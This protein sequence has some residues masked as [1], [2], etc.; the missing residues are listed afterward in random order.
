[1]TQVDGHWPQEAIRVAAR[2]LDQAGVPS[3]DHDARA[4]AAFV[5]GVAP[6]KVPLVREATEEQRR[7][8]V[9]LVRRRADREPLQHIVGYAPFLDLELAVGPGVFVP[10]PETEVMADLVREH[11][12]EIE[13]PTIVDLCTGSGAI[14][15]AVGVHCRG[16]RAHAVEA[17]ADACSYAAR[18]IAA[19]SERMT[20]QGSSVTLHC[21]DARVCAEPGGVIEELRGRADVVVSNP[22]YIPDGCVPIDPE[23]RL[24]DPDRALYGGSDGYD[25]IRPLL[26]QAVLLLRPNGLFAIEHGDL[27]GENAGDGGV[28]ALVRDHVTDGRP[29]FAEVRDNIDLAGRPRFTTAIRA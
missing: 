27:Q 1:M 28:P 2:E 15:L 5:L 21:G 9:S 4:L 24:H 17:E 8:F 14:A 18:N 12:N 7:C 23:V 3:P 11:A 29:S 22:P 13:S 6:T 25:V 16:A 19:L 10:R 20:G 26:A